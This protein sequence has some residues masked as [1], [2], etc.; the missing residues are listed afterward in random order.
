M[1]TMKLSYSTDYILDESEILYK[2]NI[3]NQEKM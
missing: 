2:I 1:K 3:L